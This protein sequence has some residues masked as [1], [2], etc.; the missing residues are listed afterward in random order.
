MVGRVG[1]LVGLGQLLGAR[2]EEQ[3]A[4]VVIGGG[5][6]SCLQYVHLFAGSIVFGLQVQ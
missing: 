1:G 2:E 4:N 3:K 5:S 6:P